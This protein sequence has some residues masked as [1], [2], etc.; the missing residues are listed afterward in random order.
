MGLIDASEVDVAAS[1]ARVTEGAGLNGAIESSGHRGALKT[2]IQSLAA[3]GTCAV[4]GVPAHGELGAFDVIDLVA[5]G[6]R[7][8][9]TNQGDANPRVVIP[10]LIAL[11]RAGRLPVDKLVT[12]FA[13][14]AVNDAASAS[15]S[16]E[17]IKPVL[18]MTE[19]VP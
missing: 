11:Y 18:I 14:D 8:V 19:S 16:G 6:L 5:R 15:L 1:I 7:I 4:V 2:A 12:T 3:A 17:A 10:R 13:Y 9:G